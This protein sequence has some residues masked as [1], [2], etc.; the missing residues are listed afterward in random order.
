M[1]R[2]TILMISATTALALSLFAGAATAQQPP[3][4]PQQQQPAPPPKP[5]KD[6]IVGTWTLLLVDDVGSDGT[7][8]PDYG[9]NAKGMLMIGPDGRYSLQIMRD[10]R[11]KFAANSRL[12]G[13]DAENKAAVQGM[14][15]HFGRYTLNE[16]DKTLTFRID[17]SSFPNWDGTQQKQQI[18]AITD[19]V[20]VYVNPASSEG[21]NRGE[22]DWRRA[23]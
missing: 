20:L 15:S 23:K 18:T 7:R 22:I 3:R 1:T 16:G 9:P 2:R 6:L 19:D 8:T 11:S 10:I 4:P 5:M 14:I 13:T 17:G 12:K 21:G